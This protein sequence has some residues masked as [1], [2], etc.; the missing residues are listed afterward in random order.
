MFQNIVMLRLHNSPLMDVIY[1]RNEFQKHK[2]DR[3]TY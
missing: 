1:S 3:F 2:F